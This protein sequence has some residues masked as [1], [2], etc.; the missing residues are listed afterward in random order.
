MPFTPDYAGANTDFRVN[1]S[2]YGYTNAAGNN[3]VNYPKAIVLH[4]LERKDDGYE[5][6]PHFFSLPGTPAGTHYYLDY[7]GDVYQML[8]EAECPYANG[9]RGGVNRT[10]KGA[11]DQWPPWATVGVTLNAQ[12]VSITIEGSAATIGRSWNDR[13]HSALL[14][15]IRN[16]AFRYAIPLD[17]DHVLGHSELA[18]DHVD[19]GE[20]FPWDRLIADLKPKLS[21]ATGLPAIDPTG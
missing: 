1:P 7:D 6:V 20:T 21:P 10:W 18:S 13:Q 5:S 4:T 12:T 3:E 17:R 14:A 11:L 2:G 19:P 15:L 8:P 16:I 9:N